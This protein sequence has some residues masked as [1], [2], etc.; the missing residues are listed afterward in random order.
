MN[1]KLTLNVDEGIIQD[2]KNYAKKHHIS[3][4][5][6]IEKYLRNITGKLTISFETKNNTITDELSGV[7]SNTNKN[8]IKDAKYLYLKEKYKL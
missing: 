5:K 8:D 6:I 2:A 3:L 1:T 4:S 7:L